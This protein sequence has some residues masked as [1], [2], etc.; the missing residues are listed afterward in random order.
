MGVSNVLK[1]IGVTAKICIPTVA[2]SITNRVSIDTCDERLAWWSQRL[3]DD[4]EVTLTVEGAENIPKSDAFVIMTNHRSYY[5][6][7]TVF[8]CIP[9]RVR[10]IAKK[11]LFYVPIFGGAMLAAGF[12]KIDREKRTKAVESLKESGE[13]LRRGVRV[14]I[15]PEGTRSR[16][17][18]L[19]AFKSGGFHLAI[20]AGVPILPIALEGTEHI[21][22][23]TGVT[24]HP[25]AHVRAQILPP[26]DAPS[27]GQKRRK[28]LTGDVRAVLARALGQD[29]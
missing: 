10:M 20:E 4:A 29:P 2:E 3:L 6:I 21:M 11:E 13:L 7:P 15:A 17:G 14:W 24:V 5:D 23:A 25:G 27:Y 19:G 9:G 18:K 26:I 28:V 12:I 8:C 1:A 16:D 22:P